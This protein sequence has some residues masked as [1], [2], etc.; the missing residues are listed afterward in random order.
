MT[1]QTSPDHVLVPIEF[2]RQFC[3]L[4]HNYSLSAIAPIY[5]FGTERDAFSSAFAEC[6]RE[7][8]K[9]R[10]MLESPPNPA[11]QY[12]PP[13]KCRQRLRVEGKAYPKSTCQSC[14]SLSPNWKQCDAA[15]AA[16]N[17]EYVW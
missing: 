3:N 5:Y 16:D 11:T 14:G 17:K 9:L 8:A 4:A 1:H 15:L 6:G 12:V 2:I 10:A 13:P 7:L